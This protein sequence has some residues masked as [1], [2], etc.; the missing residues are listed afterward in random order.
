MKVVIAPDSFKECLGAAEVASAM[1]RGVLEA[2]PEALVDLCPMADGGEGTVAAMVAATGGKLVAAD[3]FDP[4]GRPMRAHFGLLGLPMQSNLPGEIG[5]AAAVAQAGGDGAGSAG[6]RTTA[7]VETA[8]AS[9]LSL[10]PNDKRDPLRT[11][12]FGT[13]LL[14]RAALDAGANEIIVG[15]GGS[16][17]VDGG[18]GAAQALGV[19]FRDSAGRELIRGLGGGRLSEIAEID[20]RGLDTRLAGVRIRLAC[21]VTHPLCGPNGAAA[22]FGPQKGATAEMV[23]QLE[24]GLSNLAA[25]IRRKL[26]I[27]V[28]DLRGSGAAGGLGAGLVALAGAVMDS[29]VEIVASAVG[30]RH[31]LSGADL[32]ITGEGRLDSQS[33]SGKTAVGVAAIARELGVPVVCIPGSATVDAPHEAFAAVLPLA[34]GE[35]T[36]AM[37]MRKADALLT[38]RTAQALKRIIGK[39]E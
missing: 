36:A 7:V 10:V 12:T 35:V 31:R 11:T 27:D 6:G 34:G 17:T 37:A 9:G 33:R 18:C 19:V 25:C 32:C 21:D 13:G 16:A 14:I 1:A 20:T 8:A 3:V 26:G 38:H 2:C 30:L 39:T 5:L 4:L 15:L 23:V 28:A 24:A 22:V 29:G